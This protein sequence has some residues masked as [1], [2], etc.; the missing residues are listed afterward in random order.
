[1]SYRCEVCESLC[2]AGEPL[3]RHTIY[4]PDGQIEREMPVCARC[5]EE[6][7][8]GKAVQALVLAYRPRFVVPPSPPADAGPIAPGVEVERGNGPA[9]IVPPPPTPQELAAEARRGLDWQRTPEHSYQ[10]EAPLNGLAFVIQPE[11]RG[12]SLYVNGEKVQHRVA[13]AICQG[14]A[15]T[16]VR[17]SAR[18]A[19]NQQS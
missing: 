5:G 12:F 8:K 1:M 11:T 14:Y 6:L 7:R 10:A 3:R 2:R 19:A 13:L 9:V 17:R 18:A 16:L 15:Q 4:R